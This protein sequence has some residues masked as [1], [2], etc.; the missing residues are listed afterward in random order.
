MDGQALTLGT[1][2]LS[3][4]LYVAALLGVRPRLTWTLACLAYLTHAASAFHF[5]HQWSHAAA[6]AETARQTRALF[7]FGSGA[8]L[9]CNYAF[10][11]IWPADVV[12]WW[13]APA[14]YARRPRWIARAVHG[15]L[16]FMY[17][18]GAVVFASGATR[19]LGLVATAAVA[20]RW[21]WLL[22]APAASA[23]YRASDRT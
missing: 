6:Y 13:C 21:W 9:Y 23:Q 12:W 20:L 11:V 17:L 19:W 2:R 8:G 1:I 16:A 7:G 4:L 15:F 5:H 18:N 3:A 22:K 14:A 10:T